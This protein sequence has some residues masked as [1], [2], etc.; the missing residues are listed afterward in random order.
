MS[1]K[2]ILCLLVLYK[3]DKKILHEAISAIANQV[4]YIWISDNTPGGYS[5][6]DEILNIN[7]AK[8]SYEYML[9]NVGIAHAQ[10]I[11]IKYA[12]KNDYDF[13]YMLDQD[14][15][16]PLG[17]VDNLEEEF[18]R[19]RKKGIN[20]GGV[21]PQPFNRD[22]GKKYVATIKKGKLIDV[23]VREVSELINSAS[24]IDVNM[25]KDVGLMEDSLFIDAVDFELCWRASFLRG[26]RFFQ[27]SSLSLN[28][29]LGEGDRYL[30]GMA[31]KIPTPFR[32]YYLYR[33]YI[34][35][36]RRKY[37]PLYWKVSNG[38][39]FFFKYFYLSLFVTPR[40]EYF[41]NINR[42][43]CDGVFNKFDDFALDEKSYNMEA[44]C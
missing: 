18:L 38:I 13:V 37:V 11:G 2:K 12:I 41:R 17:L 39:K 31:I 15:I 35:L 28:H 24:L 22:T 42:G 1:D 32:T 4:E 43:I 40:F 36:C 20:V 29:K 25:F 7:K 5:Q 27:I 44:K 16:S 10:N 33:N 14:S 30:C 9:R 8:I 3:P 21:G 34:C 26:Y 6:I 19:L 23:S